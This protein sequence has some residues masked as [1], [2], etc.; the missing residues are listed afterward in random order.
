MQVSPLP[1][2]SPNFLIVEQQSF[3]LAAFSALLLL[4]QT[5]AYVFGSGEF[6]SI[7]N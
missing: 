3:V 6:S 2:F 4:S 5:S 7:S 1:Q